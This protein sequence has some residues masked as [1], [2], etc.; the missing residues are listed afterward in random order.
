MARTTPT[1]IWLMRAAY[2]GLALLIMFFHLLPLDTLPRRWSPPD[3]LLAMSLA[4][5]VRRPDF[6]PP[7][8]IAAVMFLADLLFQR[9]PGLWA[10]LVLLACEFARSRLSPHRETP[11]LAEWFAISVIVIGMA[12]LNRVILGILAVEQAHIALIL[13]QVIMTIAAYPLVVLLSQSVIG[14]R[15]LSAADAE[16]L[17]A[18]P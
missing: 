9:P 6:V 17:G 14:V 1:A 11:F 12:L 13:V 16:T 15:R 10:L 3:L 4:W 18:R 7:L 8:L 5:S 2:V